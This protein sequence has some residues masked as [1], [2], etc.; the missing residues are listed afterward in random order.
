MAAA[1]PFGAFVRYR[2]KRIGYVRRIKV[3]E[4]CTGTSMLL[5]ANEHNLQ[6]ER[7]LRVQKKL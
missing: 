2:F 7:I 5:T 1:H 4:M 6:L 3:K